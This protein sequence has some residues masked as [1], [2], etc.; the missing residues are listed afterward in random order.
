MPKHEFG[1]MQK[2]PTDKDR[3]DTYEPQKYNCIVVDDDLIEPILTDLAGVDCYWHTLQR[4]EKGLAYCGITLIPPKSM[5]AFTKV[6]YSQSKEEYISLIS[7]ANQAK[8]YSR[9]II[10]FGI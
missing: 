10:H 4:P 9:Y 3:F 5:D 6:L 8:E 7:L 2:Y 1:I